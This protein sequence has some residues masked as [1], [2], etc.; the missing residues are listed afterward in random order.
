MN[1]GQIETVGDPSSHDVCLKAAVE[2]LRPS[3]SNNLE[4]VKVEDREVVVSS[5]E[6]AGTAKRLTRCRAAMSI[7]LENE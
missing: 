6:R 1:K 7:A 4:E 5:L 3:T 2:T